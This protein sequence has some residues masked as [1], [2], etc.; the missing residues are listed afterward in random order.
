MT[1]CTMID[2]NYVV[3]WGGLFVFLSVMAWRDKHETY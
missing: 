3:Y 2:W 1:E